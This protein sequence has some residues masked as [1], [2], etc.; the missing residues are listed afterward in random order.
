MRIIKPTGY[1]KRQTQTTTPVVSDDT[2]VDDT[3][4]LVDDATALVGGSATSYSAMKHRTISPVP[5]GRIKI[6]R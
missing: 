5:S 6:K 1:I 2:L 3:V 4:A